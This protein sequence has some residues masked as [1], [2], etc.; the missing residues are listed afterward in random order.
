MSNYDYFRQQ[1]SEMERIKGKTVH[2]E[3]VVEFRAMCA[4]MINDAIPDIRKQ[5]LEEMKQEQRE[6][7]H[8][9]KRQPEEAKVRLNVNVENVKSQILQAIRNAFK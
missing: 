2:E 9:E 3:H 4:K 5:C 1:V 7:E 6:Q 8:V